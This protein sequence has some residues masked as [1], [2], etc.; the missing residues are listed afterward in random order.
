M[1]LLD[2]ILL[3]LAAVFLIIGIDQTMKRYDGYWAFMLAVLFLILLNYRK[4]SQK[5]TNEKI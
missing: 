4:F 3:T 5:K 1:K 2:Y